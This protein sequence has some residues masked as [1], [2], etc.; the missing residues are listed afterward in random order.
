MT[1]LSK[2]K[3]HPIY[4]VAG[5]VVTTASTTWALA[6]WFHTHGAPIREASAGIAQVV[7]PPAAPTLD[8]SPRLQS[9]PP[10]LAV[11]VGCGKAMLIPANQ[12]LRTDAFWSVACSITNTS[13]S[14][15]D[16]P[17]TFGTPG[18]W[19]M[20]SC[21]LCDSCKASALTRLDVGTKDLRF[22]YIN[23]G[24]SLTFSITSPSE[25][26][27][28]CNMMARARGVTVVDRRPE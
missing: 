14:V 20:W 18:S 16:Y 1:W 5:V 10:G 21:L 3:D 19:L 25:P 17:N 9:P 27:S 4:V 22:D 15:L 7:T 28:S 26:R 11:E 8:L 6:S 12:N 24:E 23:P 13:S 2:A